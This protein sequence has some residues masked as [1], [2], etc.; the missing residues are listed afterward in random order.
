MKS[1]QN[2]K[3][4]LDIDKIFLYIVR[5]TEGHGDAVLDYSFEIRACWRVSI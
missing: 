3:K 5:C 1:T 2:I 4:T